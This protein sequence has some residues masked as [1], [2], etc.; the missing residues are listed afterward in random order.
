M[1][2]HNSLQSSKVEVKNHPKFKKRKNNTVI[3]TIIQSS[4]KKQKVV[5]FLEPNHEKNHLT[6]ITKKMKLFNKENT[7]KS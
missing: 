5:N 6:C 2:K 7:K 4:K 1:Q 3:Q